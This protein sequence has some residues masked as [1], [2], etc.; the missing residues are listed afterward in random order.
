ML[1]RD[2]LSILTQLLNNNLLHLQSLFMF[3]RSTFYACRVWHMEHDC[4]VL[5][6]QLS[7]AVLYATRKTLTL[8]HYIKNL[9][10]LRFQSLM[11]TILLCIFNKFLMCCLFV[12]LMQSAHLFNQRDWIVSNIYESAL[13]DYIDTLFYICLI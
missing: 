7:G 11:S 2:F 9:R 6:R 1:Y 10:A 12:Q 3:F 4:R 5:H 8:I 13:V